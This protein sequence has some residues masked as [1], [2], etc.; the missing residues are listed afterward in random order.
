MLPEAYP[1]QTPGPTQARSHRQ[2]NA[3][4]LVEAHQL[5]KYYN[6]KRSFGR[7]RFTVKAVDRVDLQIQVG[8]VFG[9]VGESG[10]GKSTIGRLLLR[11]INPS[12]GQIIFDGQ[13]LSKMRGSQLAELRRSAQIV[14]LPPHTHGK[15]EHGG[16]PPQVPQRVIDVNR[17]IS[18]RWRS[19]SARRSKRSRANSSHSLSIIHPSPEARTPSRALGARK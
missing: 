10:C 19:S 11:L 13:D 5:S 1:T 17:S 2:G 4:A 12:Q 8:E 9:L 16:T 15:P 6:V 18:S 14:F 7:E 3:Q